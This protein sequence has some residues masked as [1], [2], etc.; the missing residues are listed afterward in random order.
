MDSIWYFD[1]DQK[2]G[3]LTMFFQVTGATAYNSCSDLPALLLILILTAS[4]P[5]RKKHSWFFRKYTIFLYYFIIVSMFVQIIGTMAENVEYINDNYI[6][7]DG[8]SL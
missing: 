3:I 7:V 8:S 4:W 5:F 1:Q 2:F 6:N